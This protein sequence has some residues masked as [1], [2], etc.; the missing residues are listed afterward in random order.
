MP[1]T[2]RHL[3][4]GLVAGS[5]TPAVL[6][7]V[8]ESAR[9]LAG[10]NHYSASLLLGSAA[11]AAV[12]AL[13]VLVVVGMPAFL[14]ARKFNVASALTAALAASVTGLLL[15]VAAGAADDPVSVA[16]WVG[17]SLSSGFAF[18]HFARNTLRQ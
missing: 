5:V 8:V 14:L 7:F 2:A 9:G 13:C 16:A 17:S 11:M 12:V 3:M 4:L 18:W 6:F 15:A 10:L 1:D